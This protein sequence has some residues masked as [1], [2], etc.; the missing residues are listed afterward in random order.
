MDYGVP[1]RY[2]P[3]IDL[4]FPSY[5]CPERSLPI[6]LS[7]SVRT[8]PRGFHLGG[9]VG[10]TRGRAGV[11]RDESIIDNGASRRRIAVAVSDQSKLILRTKVAGDLKA[12]FRIFPTS[13]N[14]ADLRRSVHGAVRGKSAVLEIQ[15]MVPDATVAGRQESK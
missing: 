13:C 1:R 7:H 6:E 9:P 14:L 8:D 4:S 15:V 11:E 12:F 2:S 5:Y 10:S 3:H